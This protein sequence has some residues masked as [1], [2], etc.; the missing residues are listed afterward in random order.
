MA[1]QHYNRFYTI[2]PVKLSN[3]NVLMFH[4]TASQFCTPIFAK[5][6]TKRSLDRFELTEPKYKTKDLIPYELCLIFCE[7][8][9]FS[10]KKI[11]R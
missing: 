8:D 4:L 5:I 6:S 1:Q 7:I 3:M 2:L 10:R 11:Y 9:F